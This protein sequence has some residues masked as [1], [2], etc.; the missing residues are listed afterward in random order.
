MSTETRCAVPGC[1]R[2][3]GGRR[4]LCSTHRTRQWRHGDPHQ[5][6]TPPDALAI[7]MAVANRSPLPGMRP[8]ERRAAGVRLTE[9]G[10][11]ANEIARIFQVDPRTVHRW[12]SQSRTRVAA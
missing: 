7:D 11:P 1:P 8:A 6:A 5:K 10:L 9:L 4:T 2:T 3:P 12:R